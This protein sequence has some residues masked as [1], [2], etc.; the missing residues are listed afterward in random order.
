MRLTIL[1]FIL[2][3]CFGFAGATEH[4]DVVLLKDGSVYF[5]QLTSTAKAQMIEIITREGYKFSFFYRDVESIN[6]H[7]VRP[8]NLPSYMSLVGIYY[9]VNTN[10]SVVGVRT[11]NGFRFKSIFGLGLGLG[12]DRY[13]YGNSYPVFINTQLFFSNRKFSSYTFLNFGYAL[14]KTGSKSLRFSGNNLLEVGVGLITPTRSGFA[15][16]FDGG[17]RTS[18]SG[19]FGDAHAWADRNTI[20]ISIGALLH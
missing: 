8:H 5:G 15:W 14:K 20:R 1:I 10:S 17:F 13:S 11:I 7:L 9:G 18:W 2:S 19:D 16:F 3:I 6:D 4:Q 12:V